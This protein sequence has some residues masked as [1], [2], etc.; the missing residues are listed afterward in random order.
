MTK[1]LTH[2]ITLLFALALVLVFLQPAAAHDTP[3]Q[4]G[5][6][7][8]TKKAA[9]SLERFVGTWEGRCQDGRTF[10][11]VTL[12]RN[13][14]QLGGTVSIA[15]MHGDDAGACMLVLAP[16]IP[17]YAQEIGEAV[18]KQ[19]TLSFKGS[20]RPDGTFARFELKQTDSSQAQLRFLNTPVA[21]HPWQLVKIQK[22]E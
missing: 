17:K 21:D 14:D 5:S 7:L 9:D 8:D 1:D 20:K 12:H 10:V 15:N 22:P 3:S 6:T 2:Q 16:P 18:A 19:N 13:G 11:V 4:E